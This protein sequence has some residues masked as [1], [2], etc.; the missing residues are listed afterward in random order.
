MPWLIERLTPAAD[1]ARVNFSISQTPVEGSE[2][3]FFPAMPDE[4]VAVTPILE[5]QYVR[6]GTTVTFGLP[7]ASGR[8]PW[9]RYFFESP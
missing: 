6:T 9:T 8:T 2:L 7:P 5:M 3:I 4:R 1:G